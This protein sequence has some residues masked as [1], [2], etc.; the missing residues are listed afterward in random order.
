MKLSYC[1]CRLIFNLARQRW[2]FMVS[3]YW[4]SMSSRRPRFFRKLCICCHLLSRWSILQRQFDSSFKKRTYLWNW[5]IKTWT[6]IKWKCM[7][8][9]LLQLSNGRRKGNLE[10]HRMFWWK[11]IFP[12]HYTVWS[13]WFKWKVNNQNT[14]HH[15]LEIQNHTRAVLL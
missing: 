9:I 2:L 4:W 10:I 11:C 14:K 3:R 13:G 6:R 7:F 12:K 8:T 1:N 5:G 15:E